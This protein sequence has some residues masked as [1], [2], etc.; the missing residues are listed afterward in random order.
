MEKSIK[1][2]KKLFSSISHENSFPKK[3]V[4]L[5]K[6]DSSYSPEILDEEFKEES[7]A[8]LISE[9]EESYN[10]SDSSIKQKNVQKISKNQKKRT[11]PP[12]NLDELVEF[13]RENA[14]SSY[15]SKVSNNILVRNIANFG[16]KSNQIVKMDRQGEYHGLT[17][18]VLESLLP[19]FTHLRV[20]ETLNF[21]KKGKIPAA[22][23]NLFLQEEVKVF[24]L[25]ILY[26]ALN[27]WLN[28]NDIPAF[29]DF[30]SYIPENELMNK[31]PQEFSKLCNRI[32]KN[33]H[34]ALDCRIKVMSIGL[35]K[36]GFNVVPEEWINKE[37]SNGEAMHR[38]M[39]L[40]DWR[41]GKPPVV[42]CITYGLSIEDENQW[43][44][45]QNIE[46]SSM[47]ISG[48]YI[49]LEVSDKNKIYCSINELKTA[50][51]VEKWHNA[52]EKNHK[53]L[54][55]KDLVLAIQ[56][57]NFFYDKEE[58]FYEKSENGG[59]MASRLQ[60]CVRR[61]SGASRI[62]EETIKKM[63]KTPPYN[64]PE[65]QFLRVNSNRQIFWRLFISCIEDSCPY[66][67]ELE[68]QYLGLNELVVLALITSLDCELQMNDFLLE[69]LIVTAKLIQGQKKSF[70]WRSGSDKKPKSLNFFKNEEKNPFIDVK[71]ALI[72]ALKTQNMMINDRIMLLKTFNLFNNYNKQS[73]LALDNNSISF[74]KSDENIC[75]EVLLSSYDMHCIPNMI[76]ILQGSLMHLSEE[77]QYST[78]GLSSLIWQ[79]SSS[80]NI[81]NTSQNSVKNPE[82]LRTIREI[83]E[84][85]LFNE[86]NLI[87]NFMGII[88]S[89]ISLYKFERFSDFFVEI[90]QVN[91]VLEYYIDGS[92]TE[93]DKRVAFL[94]LFGKK[95]RFLSQTTKG[96][97]YQKFLEGILCGDE[98]HPV[99]IKTITAN[100]MIYLNEKPRFLAEIEYIKEFSIQNKHFL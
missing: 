74:I 16:A 82:I 35:S 93:N 28:L 87:K 100:K 65:L 89:N 2:R 22:I 39:D 78:H 24:G 20:I 69:K 6:S 95:I 21:M 63:R 55:S 86:E 62:I 13:V 53:I 68:S 9:N 11:I 85:Y 43:A 46:I 18:Q 4:K 36:K 66:I 57:K 90:V 51:E 83:Q 56:L 58:V 48:T 59:V 3:S 31:N 84:F 8:S 71:N 47:I 17:I 42:Y 76:L 81:R 94:T 60:K 98:Q 1:K 75:K 52:L 34:D 50:G 72:L 92:L 25:D 33:R 73:L 38:E 23:N 67:K 77:N 91:P 41:L 12:V 44:D 29:P 88:E 70:D 79:I 49:Q 61:G 80:Y 32:K 37:F 15:Q 40:L 10:D 45:K 30:Q 97:K 14:K 19:L 54:M 64:L 5:L 96:Q 7:I 26:F 27:F 99:K